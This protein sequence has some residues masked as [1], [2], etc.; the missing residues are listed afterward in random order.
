MTAKDLENNQELSDR[1]DQALACTDKTY[2]ELSQLVYHLQ[3]V[4]EIDPEDES[5][6]KALIFAEDFKE[7]YRKLFDT[8][9]GW[10]VLE[11]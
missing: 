3:L 11:D 7:Q 5:V 1:L 6:K 9:L 10:C 2:F 4:R 8:D